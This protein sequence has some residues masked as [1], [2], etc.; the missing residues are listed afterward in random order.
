VLLLL[1]C[2][3]LARYFQMKSKAIIVPIIIIHLTSFSPMSNVSEGL[4]ET[5]QDF[6]R[7]VVR[8]VV[9]DRVAHR[10]AI[11]LSVVVRCARA[12]LPN[13]SQ[14]LIGLKIALM[15]PLKERISEQFRIRTVPVKYDR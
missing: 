13:S 9:N 11:L 15:Q 6:W 14:L 4:D 3:H 1:F 12:Y 8:V 10:S 7:L 5:S 2:C